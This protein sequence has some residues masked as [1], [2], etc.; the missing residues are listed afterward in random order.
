LEE[1]QGG[2]G[3]AEGEGLKGTAEGEAEAD[4]KEPDVESFLTI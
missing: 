2:P 4:W 1:E 3:A